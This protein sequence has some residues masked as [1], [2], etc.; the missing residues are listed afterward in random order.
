MIR[1]KVYRPMIDR[2][3]GTGIHTD[4]MTLIKWLR[5]LGERGTDWDFAG[6]GRSLNLWFNND[7]L[8]ALYILKWE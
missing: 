6:S 7:S 1:G 3:Y 4:C 5:Q 2:E 8:E